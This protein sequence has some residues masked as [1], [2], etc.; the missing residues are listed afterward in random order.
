V[1]FRKKQYLV[2]AYPVTNLR[3]NVEQIAILAVN[4]SDRKRAVDAL[5][6]ANKKIGLLDTV[7]FN[8]IQNT[9]FVQLGY[10]HLIRD[11]ISDPLLLKYIEKE[12]IA[13]RDIQSSLDFAK[14]YQQMGVQPPQWQNVHRVLLFAI[15]HLSLGSVTFKA[16]VKGLE[17][18]AD[19]LLER[20]LY[21]ILENT[22]MHAQGVSAIRVWYRERGDALVLV[23]EDDG[24]G[25]P[26]GRKEQIFEKGSG[27]KGSGGLF[28]CREILSITNATISETGTRSGARFEICVPLGSFRFTE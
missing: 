26:D 11:I 8:D 5:Q 3:N 19:L 13:A 18:Y 12:E 14:E 16:E 9:V 1:E 28:L 10:F 17:I 4:I 23:I 6:Q 22:L 21:K 27:S 25:I 20:V 24:P 2:S 15:S 7:I